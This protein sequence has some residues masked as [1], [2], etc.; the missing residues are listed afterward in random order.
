MKAI[1]YTEARRNL[2]QKMQE[3]ADNREALLITRV[4]GENCVLLS[5]SEYN[6]LQ[7]TAYLLRSPAN[8]AHLLKGMSEMQEGLGVGKGL[9]E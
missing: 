1:T 9:L 3:V 6:A 5:E 8:A 4:R 7:E 2:T